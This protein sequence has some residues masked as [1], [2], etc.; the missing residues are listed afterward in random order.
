[1]SYRIERR[2][3]PLTCSAYERDVGICVAC[4]RTPWSY[5]SAAGDGCRHLVD[6]LGDGVVGRPQRDLVRKG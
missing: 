2:L 6:D 1:M 5:L 3:E 4:R